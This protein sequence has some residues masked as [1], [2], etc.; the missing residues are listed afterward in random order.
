MHLRLPESDHRPQ[1]R[2]GGALAS[3]AL[4]G[5]L[6]AVAAALTAKGA[7]STEPPRTRTDTTLIYIEPPPPT[8]P[9]LPYRASRDGAPSRDPAP[10]PLPP[11]PVTIPGEIP[12]PQ[13]PGSPIVRDE[14]FGGAGGLV[15]GVVEGAGIGA[16]PGE[17]G[18]WSGPAVEREVVPDPRNPAPGY[19]ALLRTRGVE[20]EAVLRFVVDTT[21]RVEPGSAV[22]LSADDPAFGVAV[23]RVLPRLRFAPARVGGRAVRQLVQQAF[24]FE[25]TR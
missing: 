15:A 9:G 7:Q 21:G 17:G 13:L 1:R 3:L 2:A 16:G 14:H 10:S 24:R 20:G 12:I 4:H 22:V 11:P 25:L 8:P 6:I 23:V 19:P 5:A 18:I